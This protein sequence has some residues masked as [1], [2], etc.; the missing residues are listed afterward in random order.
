MS[1]EI[2]DIFFDKLVWFGPLKVVKNLSCDKHSQSNHPSSKD[3]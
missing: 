1:G 3:F 2:P